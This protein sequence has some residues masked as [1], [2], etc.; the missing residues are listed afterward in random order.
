LRYTKTTAKVERKG[1]KPYRKPS[2][3]DTSELFG[4]PSAAAAEAV[5]HKPVPVHII[6]KTPKNRAINILC[7]YL[8]IDMSTSPNMLLYF[9]IFL[10]MLLC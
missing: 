7:R 3:V 1:I 10:K 9:I 2:S 8:N 5:R 4:D 6:I